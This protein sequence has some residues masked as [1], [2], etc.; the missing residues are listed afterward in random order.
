MM[1]LSVNDASCRTFDFYE[2]LIELDLITMSLPARLLVPLSRL[3]KRPAVSRTHLDALIKPLRHPATP[4]RAAS[5]LDLPEQFT[6]FTDA[7][8]NRRLRNLRR[9][10]TGVTFG[11][12]GYAFGTFLISATILYVFEPG[13]PEDVEELELLQEE[14]EDLEDIRMLKGHGE[15]V[16]DDLFNHLSQGEK[17]KM[18][19]TG[20]LKGS[21]GI[22]LMVRGLPPM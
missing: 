6:Q 11:G 22:N 14:F 3:P 21:R 15:F 17:E 7:V 1:D 8:R 4:L 19:I 9:L 12:L 13:S 20:P 16:Q 10:L 5:S 2:Y 18:L